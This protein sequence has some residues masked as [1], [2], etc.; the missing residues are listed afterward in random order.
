MVMMISKYQVLDDATLV[1]DFIV[2][3]LISRVLLFLTDDTR[4][5]SRHDRSVCQQ[6]VLPTQ[7]QG[8]PLQAN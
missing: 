6:T 3:T 5:P 7:F 4:L 2:V 1:V 8:S